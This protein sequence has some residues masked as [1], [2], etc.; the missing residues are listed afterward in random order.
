MPHDLTQPD[1]RRV[2]HVDRLP[3]KELPP[4]IVRI[5]QDVENGRP[6]EDDRTE[7]ERRTVPRLIKWPIG[8][9]LAG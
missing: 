3:I 7:R 9:C 8:V 4:M 6:A 2:G 5:V 1:Q